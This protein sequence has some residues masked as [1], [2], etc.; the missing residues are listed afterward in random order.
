[1]SELSLGP[2]RPIKPKKRTP[3]PYKI[4][5]DRP[6]LDYLS[7]HFAT[8][9]NCDLAD[10]L[11]I[12]YRSVIRKAREL[13]LEKEPGF[14]EKNRI[15]ITEMATQAHPPHPHKGERG[16][17]IPNSE[18][19]RF[20]PGHISPMSYNPALVSKVHASRNATIRTERL[21]LK[22]GLSRKTK[23]NLKPY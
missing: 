16:W 10:H 14:L 2:I 22:Y 23:L 9:F 19:T 12:S 6:M 21:R 4:I 3:R 5:W 20:K 11:K 17:I 1:M 15:T 18:N 8:Q 13:G 7:E